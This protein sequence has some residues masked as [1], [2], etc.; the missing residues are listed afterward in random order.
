MKKIF[1][2]LVIALFTV[3]SCCKEDSPEIDGN[4]ATITLTIDKETTEIGNYGFSGSYTVGGPVEFG[5][6][7]SL[8]L[9]VKA[10]IYTFLEGSEVQL[11][12]E[13]GLQVEGE[14]GIIPE[15][16]FDGLYEPNMQFELLSVDY[17][18]NHIFEG[19]SKIVVLV[20]LNN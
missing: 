8:K 12:K 4:P 19:V 17:V 18:E 14:S 15:T 1:I 3:T 5:K 20:N 11:Q 6:V 13:I 7:A 16:L 10:R 2:A 9:T